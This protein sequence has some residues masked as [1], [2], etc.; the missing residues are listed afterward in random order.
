[1]DNQKG[2]AIVTGAS[3]GIG[4]ELAKLFARD[5]YSLLLVA[6]SGEKLRTVSAELASTYAIDAT[7]CRVDLAEAG[8]CDQVL[9]AAQKSNRP[10]HVLVNNA[11]FGS[12]GPFVE[13]DPQVTLGMLQVNI[14]ALTALT[15]LF[16]PSM[17]ARKCGRILNVS[18]VAAF[19]PG[20]LMAVYYAS[21]AYVLHFSEALADELRQTGVT[22]TALCP[23]PTATGF[24]QRATLG[25]SWLFSGGG[26]LDARMVAEVG[27]R[28]LMQ[29]RRIVIPGLWHKLLVLGERLVPRRVVVRIVRG[30][31]ERR[32]K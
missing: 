29:G 23:G 15:R 4:Y 21:K 11:G 20:P 3:G 17:V 27:Y 28:G 30:L 31:Q 13:T 32:G 9:A 16:L 14:V 12:W 8:A 26:A 2:I 22:V 18:S 10:V 5:G 1:M 7:A 19:Q 25:E 24:E 6:R